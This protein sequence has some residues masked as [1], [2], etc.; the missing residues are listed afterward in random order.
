MGHR[1]VI[2]SGILEGPSSG[3]ALGQSPPRVVYYPGKFLDFTLPE[4][5]SEPNWA[6]IL[7]VET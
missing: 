6:Q 1:K 7:S 4:I 2:N 3:L 5:E